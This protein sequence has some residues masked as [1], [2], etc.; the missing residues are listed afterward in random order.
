M[1]KQ[2]NPS[3]PEKEFAARTHELAGFV[4]MA[5]AWQ[6][7]GGTYPPLVVGSA[8]HTDVL[9]LIDT[10]RET[11]KQLGILDDVLSELARYEVADAS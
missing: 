2:L 1:K 11:M 4:T 8:F 5:L 7:S 6:D 9:S 3:S 10:Y